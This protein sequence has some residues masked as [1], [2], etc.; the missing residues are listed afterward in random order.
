MQRQPSLGVPLQLSSLL[1]M[2][3]SNFAGPTD[4][5][6]APQV[7]EVLSAATT[8]V[9]VPALHGPL[10]SFPGW[11]PQACVLPEVQAHTRSIVLSGEPSQSL[12]AAEVQSRVPLFTA[13]THAPQTPFVQVAVPGLQIPTAAGPHACVSPLTQGHPSFAFP[14]QVASSPFTEQLSMAAGW[15]LQAPHCPAVEQV[16]VPLAQFPSAPAV[17]QE[18]GASVLTQAQPSFAVPLQLSSFPFTQLSAA[19]GPTAPEQAPQVEEVLSAATTQL[20]FPAVQ[21]P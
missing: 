14:L 18:R 20:C 17:A 4:P 7:E 19:A 6:Q 5:L 1:L 15:T 10:P 8:Q 2:Q 11:A 12:S 13:P 3:V 21:G 9:C 16:W